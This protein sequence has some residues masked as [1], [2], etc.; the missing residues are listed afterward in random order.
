MPEPGN[1]RDK[2]FIVKL[3]ISATDGSEGAE[4]A[5]VIVAELA[6]V[7]NCK[8]LIV[9]VSAEKLS[10]AEL[11]LFDELR[12]ACRQARLVSR[13]SRR[14]WRENLKRQYRRGEARGEAAF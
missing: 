1:V 14:V 8:L 11:R 6:K 3:P 13:S 2:L 4:R 7:A 9:N 10:P 5:V 12:I